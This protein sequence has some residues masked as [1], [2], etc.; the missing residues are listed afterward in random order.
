MGSDRGKCLGDMSYAD[1]WSAI[2]L[3]CPERVPRTEFSAHDYHYELMK[4]VTGIDVGDDSPNDVKLAA[5]QAFI[6]KWNY[7]LLFA[8]QIDAQEFGDQKTNMGH[9]AYAAN[10]MDFDNDLH[11]AFKDPEEVLSFDPWQAYGEIDQELTT[12]RFEDG[13]RT[14]CELFPTNV[15]MEGIYI[16]LI[17]GL[18]YIF[19]WEMLLLAAGMDSEA[20]GELTN[21]YASWIQQ[22][23][24]ALANAE[25][26]IVW[27]HDDM[28]WAEGAIFH[29]DWYRKYI[30]PNYQRLWEPLIESGK[31]IIFVCDGDYT[32][33][34]DDVAACGI[35]GFWLEIFTDLE[36][37]ADRYGQTHVLIGNVDTRAL[38]S[39]DKDDIRT[40]VERCMSIGKGCPGYFISVSNH[41]PANT[42]VQS[43]LYYNEVYEELCKR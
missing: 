20:F 22:Y 26:P 37:V 8:D 41:I 7:D 25:I 6:Q 40:E 2:H 4:A 42:P 19:G 10:G 15:N 32:Q 36:Y 34:V 3:E 12:T 35:H 33:F 16:T 27:S 18:T 43:A 5:C 14:F 13:Y 21:R 30:F 17:T 11:I 9:G 39:G 1:G 23:Y 28:V 38:L 31:K 24:D 29:P